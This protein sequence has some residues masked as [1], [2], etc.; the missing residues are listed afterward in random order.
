MARMLLI[1]SLSFFPFISCKLNTV[2]PNCNPEDGRFVNGRHYVSG[3]MLTEDQTWDYLSIQK[4]YNRRARLYPDTSCIPIA[5]EP[6]FEETLRDTT[7][8]IDLQGR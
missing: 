7:E 8:A 6:S 5:P 3:N 4:N 1:F 2:I